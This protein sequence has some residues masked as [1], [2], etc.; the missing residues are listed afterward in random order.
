MCDVMVMVLALLPQEV[1]D[2]G[3]AVGEATFWD[4]AV[5]GA[6]GQVNAF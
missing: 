4:E 2:T 1:F 3:R 5:E 6:A